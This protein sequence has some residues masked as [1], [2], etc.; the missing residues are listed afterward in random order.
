MKELIEALAQLKPY[1]GPFVDIQLLVFLAIMALVISRMRDL[2]GAVML[3]G[4]FSL[5][6]AGLFVVM[7]AVDVAFTEAS[8]GVGI[9]TVLMLAAL[10][11]TTSKEKKSK[12]PIAI[13]PLIAVILTGAT[14]IYATLDMPRYGTLDAPIHH[15]VAD[16][17][18]KES[19]ER[20]GSPNIVTSVLASYRGYDTMGET[21]VIFTAGIGVL[22]LLGAS[23]RRKDPWEEL[24]NTNKNNDDE[25]SPKTNDLLPNDNDNSSNLK[26]KE[27]K[28]DLQGKNLSKVEKKENPVKKEEFRQEEKPFKSKQSQK[29][30][31]RIAK[32]KHKDLRK[33]KN[34]QKTKSDAKK[35]VKS[36]S[37]RKKK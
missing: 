5:I 28:E 3:T 29:D 20:T 35:R 15:H 23:K 21:T 27:K 10:S 13:I 36:D 1:I 34:T 31:D 24:H 16:K 8:V 14:L 11:L 26:K 12:K 4:I 9:S 7:D 6:S 17:Y 25:L 2:F 22:L 32:K 18:I 37:K 33:G 19:K 30:K